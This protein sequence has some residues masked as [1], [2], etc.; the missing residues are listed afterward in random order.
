MNYS[1]QMIERVSVM[2]KAMADGTRL[3][4]LQCLRDGEKSV[5]A[6]RQIVGGSQANVSKHLS[7]LKRAGLVGNRRDGMNSLYSIADERVFNICDSVC[8]S[9]GD[10]LEREQQLVQGLLDEAPED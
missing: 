4:I 1:D 10:Q 3:K 9:I 6:I 8:S 2:L 7:V 5:N